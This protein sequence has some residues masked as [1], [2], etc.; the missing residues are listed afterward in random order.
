MPDYTD[1]QFNDYLERPIERPQEITNLDVEQQFESLPAGIVTGK[2][3]GR[4]LIINL[5]TGEIISRDSQNVRVYIKDGII[6][7]SR[8]G[9]DADTTP[10]TNLILDGDV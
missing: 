2:L 6:K 9:Y 10:S 8:Q 7:V 4:N 5:D 3:V 1:S